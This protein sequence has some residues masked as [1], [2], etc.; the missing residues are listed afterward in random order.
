MPL[1]LLGAVAIKPACP[2]VQEEQRGSGMTT[3]ESGGRVLLSSDQVLT[4]SGVCGTQLGSEEEYG[5]GFLHSN[6]CEKVGC[7]YQKLPVGIV[8]K[9]FVWGWISDLSWC[10][11]YVIARQSSKSFAHALSL[12][13]Q[14]C[15]IKFCCS[16]RPVLCT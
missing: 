14:V 1:G 16:W 8:I 13:Y 10:M 2:S 15:A 5:T 7:K 11:R 4:N 9:L 6:C 12:N 3:S